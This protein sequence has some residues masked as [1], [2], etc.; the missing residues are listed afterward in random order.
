M[1]LDFFKRYEFFANFNVRLNLIPQF[2]RGNL[3]LFIYHYFN[4]MW[5]QNCGCPSCELIVKMVDLHLKIL[6]LKFRKFNHRLWIKMKLLKL[7]GQVLIA[8]FFLLGSFEQRFLLSYLIKNLT[9]TLEGKN[10]ILQR[11]LNWKVNLSCLNFVR[12]FF[13]SFLTLI[14]E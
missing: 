10:G 9:T 14:N 6:H 11:R 5:V 8:L 12:C 4:Y 13:K 1:S 7:Q 3:K 2:L